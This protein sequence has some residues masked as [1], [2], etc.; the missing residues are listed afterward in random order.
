MTPPFYAARFIRKLTAA[1][2]GTSQDVVRRLPQAMT[3]KIPVRFINGQWELKFGGA[4][5]VDEGACAELSLSATAL[6]DYRFK[7]ALT[8]RRNIPILPAG[9]ELY[10]ALK[11]DPELA[12]GLAGYFERPPGHVH[13]DSRQE[14]CSEHRFIRIQL[15]MPT[16]QQKRRSVESGGLWLRIDGLSDRGIESSSIRLPDIPGL[17]TRSAHSLNHACTLLSEVIETQR[18]AH[19][20]NVY[21][22]VLYG[23]PNGWWHPLDDLRNQALASEE[24]LVIKRLWDRVLAEMKSNPFSNQRK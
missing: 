19:T 6:T 24:R 20:T 1:N 8:R 13:L 9:A 15:G 18:M 4:I 3:I 23:E 7:L 17:R 21:K 2:I 22:T 12:P 10:I 16:D 14:I 11:P 5:P